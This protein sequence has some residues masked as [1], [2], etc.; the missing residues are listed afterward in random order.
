MF[1]TEFEYIVHILADFG[2]RNTGGQGNILSWQISN[3]YFEI[4]GT[5][6]IPLLN[7]SGSFEFQSARKGLNVVI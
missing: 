6:I 7:P 1:S 5:E 4:V 2:N 3:G